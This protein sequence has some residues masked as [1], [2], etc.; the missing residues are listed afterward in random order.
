MSASTGVLYVLFGAL[1]QFKINWNDECRLVAINKTSYNNKQ[2][3]QLK[4]YF[5]PRKVFTE[6]VCH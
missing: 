3:K 4:L 5:V 1:G 6:I 2:Q